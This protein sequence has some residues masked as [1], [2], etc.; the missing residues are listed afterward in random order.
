M[1]DGLTHALQSPPDYSSS[2]TERVQIINQQVSKIIGVKSIH[3]NDMNYRAA[4]RISVCF[5]NQ[6][7]LVDSGDISAIYDMS[8]F[9][10][11]K[12]H[13]Y[14]YSLRQLG[15][16]T[17]DFIS[18]GLPQPKSVWNQLPESKTSMKLVQSKIESVMKNNL[19]IL[20]KGKILEIVILDKF[21][22]LDGKP[23]TVFELLFSEVD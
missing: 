22:M 2:F 23:A 3:D 21:T 4:Q 9:I 1:D 20:I 5:N 10:S 18:I 6:E 11:S 19:Y 16:P 14:T 8:I 15:D 7:E 12:G 17:F 13:F